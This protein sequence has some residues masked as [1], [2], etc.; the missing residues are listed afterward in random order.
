MDTLAIAMLRELRRVGALASEDLAARLQQPLE[1][2]QRELL[3]N[4]FVFS[5]S[6]GE[7]KWSVI[8]P[9]EFAA[10][11]QMRRQLRPWQVD[12]MQEWLVNDRYGV[13]EAVTG[14]GKTDVGVAAIADARRRGVPTVVLVPDRELVD[15]W[16]RVLEEAFP[17]VAIGRLSAVEGSSVSQRMVVTTVADMEG[18]T[19]TGFDRGGL[20]VADEIQR[21]SVSDYSR[22]ML[23]L[24]SFEERLGLT[25]AYEWPAEASERLLRPFFGRTIA[26]CDY[27]RAISESILAPPSVLT[28]GVSF[29]RAEKE[30]YDRLSKR[31]DRAV[32]KLV[33]D[34]VDTANGIYAA[35]RTIAADSEV[36]STKFLA[37]EYLEAHHARSRVMAECQAK[38]AAVGELAHGLDQAHRATIFTQNDQASK[39]AVTAVQS[40]DVPS[41]AIYENDDATELIGMFSSGALRVLA[42]SRLLDEGVAVPTS[43][44]GIIMCASRK[45]GQMAQRMG[46]VIAPAGWK[47]RAVV[48]VIY[49]NGTIEDPLVHAEDTYFETL[50]DA[51]EVVEDVDP[52][53]AAAMLREWLADGVEPT[54]EEPE[55]LHQDDSAVIRSDDWS[56]DQAILDVFDEYAGFPT[57]GELREVLPDLEVE[58]RLMNGLDGVNW[59]RVGGHLVGAGGREGSQ[60]EERI[61]ALDRLAATFKRLNDRTLTPVE[62][63][64]ALS[65]SGLL[66]HRLSSWRMVELWTTLGGR[67]SEDSAPQPDSG[68]VIDAVE[69]PD[70]PVSDVRPPASRPNWERRQK[71]APSMPGIVGRGP[72]RPR[73][74]VAPRQVVDVD[75]TQEDAL[76][77]FVTAVVGRGGKSSPYAGSHRHVVTVTDKTGVEHVVRVRGGAV[78]VWKGLRRDEIRQNEPADVCAFVDTSSDPSRY[79]LIPAWI[80]ADRVRHAVDRWVAEKRGRPR[81]GPLEVNLEFVADGLN[82]WGLLG[83]A[84][85]EE[86]PS[87]VATSVPGTDEVATTDVKPVDECPR[88]SSVPESTKS[89]KQPDL[90][91]GVKLSADGEIRATL[92][93]HGNEYVGFHNPQ[94][95]MF[96]V[97]RAPGAANLVDRPFRNAAMAAA[98]LKSTVAGKLVFGIGGTEW[99]VDKT[100]GLNLED[101]LATE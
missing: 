25:A 95:G 87:S 47:R 48:V 2:V 28:V 82:A 89:V 34:G 81:V 8:G 17:G 12:A 6:G 40:A 23:P 80:Y 93:Y 62:L 26:G 37:R 56:I 65:V 77:A 55:S 15:Q 88:R 39:S 35:A 60:P 44:V 19:F 36:G 91:E 63:G 52:A 10:A 98:S 45:R 43:Q 83:L 73:P 14:S 30:E 99:V 79:Y 85:D 64:Q 49:V 32:R 21:F 20:L 68:A 3:G 100:S 59:M 78:G 84:S 58:E 38:A 75:R 4:D 11:L 67:L 13:V 51:A 70:G 22:G 24:R 7:R 1:L 33:D 41:S 9:A 69:L 50:R 97:A 86:E 74:T 18:R 94:T 16:T 54:P 5:P 53:T 42:T 27:Q 76:K 31:V 66:A 101:Y 92:D 29:R 46:R 61:S 71:S 57:W 72:T 96:R 90:I